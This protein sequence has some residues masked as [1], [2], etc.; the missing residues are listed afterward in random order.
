MR[1][2]SVKVLIFSEYVDA[3]PSGK[4]DLT[5]VDRLRQRKGNKVIATDTK[6]V[7]DGN[8][9]SARQPRVSGNL[10]YKLSSS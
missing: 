3:S 7:G 8:M 5:E 2:S 10:E 1:K 6:Q 4:P 9:G